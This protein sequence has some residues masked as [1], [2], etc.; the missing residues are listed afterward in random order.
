ME[1]DDKGLRAVELSDLTKKLV[2][3]NDETNNVFY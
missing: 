2:G 3:L 1:Q